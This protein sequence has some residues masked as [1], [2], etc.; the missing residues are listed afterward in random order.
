MMETNDMLHWV[1]L[2]DCVRVLPYVD[3]FRSEIEELYLVVAEPDAPLGA[4]R[5]V[6]EGHL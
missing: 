6:V 4:F 2:R 5:T 1:V 3:E